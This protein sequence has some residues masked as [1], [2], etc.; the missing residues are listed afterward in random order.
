MQQN[1]LARWVNATREDPRSATVAWIEGFD[2][3]TIPKQVNESDHL[4][5][6]RSNSAVKNDEAAFNIAFFLRSSALS[7]FRC[8][9]SRCLSLLTP[10]RS[11]ALISP[12]GANGSPP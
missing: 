6:G 9:I 8:L 4:V 12:S 2:P 1:V 3:E 10:R 5:V 7:C 11:L